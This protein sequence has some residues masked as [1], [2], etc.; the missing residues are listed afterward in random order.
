MTPSFDCPTTLGVQERPSSD[1]T[2]MSKFF[3]PMMK[4]LVR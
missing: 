2:H 1:D 4:G 3:N